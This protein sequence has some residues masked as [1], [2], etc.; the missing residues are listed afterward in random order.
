MLYSNSTLVRAT[1]DLFDKDC[2]PALTATHPRNPRQI[3]TSP[4]L[5]AMPVR[6]RATESIR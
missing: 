3:R 6:S 5:S 1:S 2:T 4:L